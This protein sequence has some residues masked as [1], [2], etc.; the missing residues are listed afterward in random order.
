MLRAGVLTM[1]SE[2]GSNDTSYLDSRIPSSTV[3]YRSISGYEAMDDKIGELEA[4][5]FRTDSVPHVLH[6]AIYAPRKH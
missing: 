3:L 4:D 5:Q 2:L 6:P 1:C